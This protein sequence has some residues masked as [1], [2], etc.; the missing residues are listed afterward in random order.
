M[1]LCYLYFISILYIIYRK[2][3]SSL[4]CVESL[5]YFTSG[6]TLISHFIALTFFFHFK[7]DRLK[8]E[9]GPK[10]LLGANLFN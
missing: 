3:E 7:S 10:I 5:M 4:K 1:Y 2:N 8:R 6:V 9:I